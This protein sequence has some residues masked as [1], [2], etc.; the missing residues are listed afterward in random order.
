[1]I[2]TFLQA[3]QW[4][5]VVLPTTER[6]LDKLNRLRGQVF[7]N[8]QHDQGGTERTQATQAEL[9]EEDATTEGTVFEGTLVTQGEV[10]NLMT[11][12]MTIGVFGATCP[13]LLLLTPL[14]FWFQ[15]CATRWRQSTSHEPF[16]KRLASQILVQLPV[17]AFQIEGIALAWCT[18]SFVLWDLGAG[19]GPVV[20]FVC[21]QVI[22]LCCLKLFHRDNQ[23]QAD[24][25]PQTVTFNS[26]PRH[27]TNLADVIWFNNSNN[28]GV[29][30]E[31]MSRAPVRRHAHELGAMREHGQDVQCI[32]FASSKP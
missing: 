28:D 18:T 10:V 2:G 27:T 15:L 19:I 11:L 25:A 20:L 8:N 26:S 4:L 6:A 1:M 5:L 13:L 17:R 12:M 23:P 31:Q 32:E 21:L 24:I 29:I 3:T 30:V 22:S 14:G 9:S 16:G 7:G